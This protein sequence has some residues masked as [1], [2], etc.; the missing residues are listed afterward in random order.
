MKSMDIKKIGSIVAG[1]AMLGAALSAPVIA[2]LDSTG[3][4][5]GFFYDANFN[6]IVQI[7]VGE[8]GMATD[9]VAAGNIAATVGNLAY[10][11]KTVTPTG[12]TYVPEGQVVITTAARGAIGDYQQDT[13]IEEA[14]TEF[15]DEDE[16]FYFDGGEKNYEKGDFTSY[17]LECDKQTRVEA[18]L[19]MTG[20]YGNVHCL[21]CENL[22]ME[23][24]ENPT[25]D[26]KEIIT[27]DNDKIH[28]Y[29]TGVDDDDSE[30]VKMAIDKDAIKYTVKTGYIPMEKL[31]DGDE[32][33]DFEYRG[34]II[35]FGEEYYVKDIE[36]TSKIY[37]C[38]GKVLDGVTSEGFTAEYNGY[39]FKID[40][41][42]Y[43]AEYTVAGI[44]L[45]V[46]KPDGTVVQVQI[47][48]MANG[49]IDDLE[50]AGVYAEEAAALQSASIIVYDLSTQVVLE[51]GE[52]LE[53]GGEVKKDW[54]VHF[55][56]FVGSCNPDASDYLTDCEISEY[57][58][59]DEE[60]KVLEKIEIVYEKTLDGDEALE[61]DESL[62]FPNNFRLTFKGFMTNDFR[63]SPCSGDGEGNIVLDKGGAKYQLVMSLTGEDNNRYDNVRLDEGPFSKNDLFFANGK[64]WMYEKYEKK[65]HDTG[66]TDDEVK[67]TLDPVI[68]GS[69]LKP[70]LVRFCD[71]EDNQGTVAGCDPAT[72]FCDCEDIALAYPGRSETEAGKVIVR[73]LALT[74]AIDDGETGTNLPH[75]FG[76]DDEIKLDAYDL[77]YLAADDPANPFGI[78]MFFDDGGNTIVFT[79]DLE[80]SVNADMVGHFDDFE[81][82]DYDLEFY[83]KNENGDDLNG[84][85]D[86]DDTLVIFEV[87]DGEVVVDMTDRDY[88]ENVRYEYD[89][90][91]ALWN[92]GLVNGTEIIE[93]GEDLDTML[94][95]PDGGDEFTI[96]WGSDNRVDAVELCHPQ[97]EVD[98]T[99]FIGTVE[100]ETTAES[101][102]TKADEGKEIT[103]GC[104][105]F[106]VSKFEVT[107][108]EGTTEPVTTVD[109]RPIV[110]N[111]V[112][113]EVAADT[114][115]NLII[116]GGPAVNGMCTISKDEISAA[117]DKYVVKKVGNM[118]MVAGWTADDT[119]AAGNA[120][121]N[122]LKANVHA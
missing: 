50:I 112:V 40:H 29:E 35:L 26:M 59:V 31:N 1:T 12:P 45:D 21:F 41:L 86:I 109:V 100:E 60:D 74:D 2:G 54:E 99:Y 47:S 16:G 6:P 32:T 104:C 4:T 14:A 114:S 63:E 39:K 3:L 15:Y 106:T 13:E 94:V 83:V 10:M 107:A 36:G 25:H 30:S 55:D 116:V 7:V 57:D 82:D 75:D 76:N 72:T 102:I 46:E 42:I 27:I 8:K 118:V 37:L 73:T 91:V 23:G 90:N 110:G 88:N 122:W 120:L 101:V 44:L 38:K 111:M 97:D 53:I 64:I 20:T 98:A 51:D 79:D 92:P 119:V 96:D 80:L 85:G 81:T 78:T 65:D 5:K 22:C 52:D 49:E 70:T 33:V 117:P 9:A 103:A 34:K 121:I 105:T 95:V 69:K 115:K 17:T 28:Y 108:G 24:L 56:E 87:E 48:R 43:A 67:V 113:P 11:T 89:T 84:D 68:R 62:L 58:N 71:P 77:F 18:G 66:E 61:K 19:L 93:M